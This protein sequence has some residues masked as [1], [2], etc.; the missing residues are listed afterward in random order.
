MCLHLADPV[1]P[2]N[3]CLLTMVLCRFIVDNGLTVVLPAV[4]VFVTSVID[5]TDTSFH[6]TTS[7]SLMLTRLC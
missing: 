5:M 4:K 6:T 2:C 3:A 7:V 1:E